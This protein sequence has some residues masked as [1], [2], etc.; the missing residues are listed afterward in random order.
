MVLDDERSECKSG[1][2][3]AQGIK[4]GMTPTGREHPWKPVVV[5]IIAVNVVQCV[6]VNFHTQK[7]R[8]R[9][10]NHHTDD[11]KNDKNTSARLS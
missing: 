7:N 2:L 8:Q 1:D 11:Q 10:Q 6:T 5:L 3:Q 4:G 9:T